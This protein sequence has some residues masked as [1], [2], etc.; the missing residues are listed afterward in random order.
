MSQKDEKKADVPPT[1]S[2]GELAALQAQGA[3]TVIDVRSPAS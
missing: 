1:V 3:V 2:V